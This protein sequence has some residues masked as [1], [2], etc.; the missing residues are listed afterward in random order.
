M[1]PVLRPA[2]R[3]D[4]PLLGRYVQDYYRFEGIE[5]NLYR[6]ERA[7]LPLLDSADYGRVWLIECG[8]DTIGYI[9][10][11]FSWSVEC[12]GRDALID[13]FYIAEGRRGRGYGQRALQLVLEEARNLGVV[14][15]YLEVGR[16]NL[17]GQSFYTSLGFEARANYYLMNR[18]IRD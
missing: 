13:E 3:E 5:F 16:D 9:I 6:M 15:V 11:C 7:L 1:E 14:S 4:L 17:R 12:G 2:R 10:L 18:R 8:P